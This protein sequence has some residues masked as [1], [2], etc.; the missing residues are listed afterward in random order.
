MSH[1]KAWVASVALVI[2]SLLVSCSIGPALPLR[3]D[4]PTQGL[5]NVVT[6]KLT[7]PAGTEKEVTVAE[8]RGVNDNSPVLAEQTIFGKLSGSKTQDT[9]I[10]LPAGTVVRALG[11][12]KTK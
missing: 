2:V 4:M 12:N 5:E 7:G 11:M 3:S 9:L 10:T 8:T 1:R 6:Y